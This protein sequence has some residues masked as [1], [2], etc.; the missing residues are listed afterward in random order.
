[1]LYVF[2][3]LTILSCVTVIICQLDPAELEPLLTGLEGNPY[4]NLSLEK[5]VPLSTNDPTVAPLVDLQV[6]APPVVPKS[7]QSCQL[8]LLKHTFGIS[9]AQN[10]PKLI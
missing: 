5:R 9:V 7:S 3:F 4:A 10:Q 8:Q 1:M 2:N 6:F